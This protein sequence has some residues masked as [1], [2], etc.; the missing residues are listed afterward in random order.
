VSNS[1]SNQGFDNCTAGVLLATPST[2]WVPSALTFQLRMSNTGP[3]HQCVRYRTAAG[4]AWADLTVFAS[5]VAS[6]F[7]PVTI[8]LAGLPGVANNPDLAI[9]VA[10]A[11]APGT[12]AYAPALATSSY[13]TS[14]WSG[15]AR[16]RSLG[17]ARTTAQ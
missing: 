10:S 17:A 12:E 15:T 8:P 16:K 7:E 4:G 1:W 9:L 5:T 13:G 3:L 11:F 14:E 2:G 6:A